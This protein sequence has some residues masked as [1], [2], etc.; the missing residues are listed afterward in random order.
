LTQTLDEKVPSPA[1]PPSASQSINKVLVATTTSLG[2]D[3]KSQ[4]VREMNMHLSWINIYGRHLAFIA[5][6]D[7]SEARIPSMTSL[8]CERIEHSDEEKNCRKSFSTS[9]RWQSVKMRN[10]SSQL[11]HVKTNYRKFSNKLMNKNSRKPSDEGLENSRNDN[12]PCGFARHK[13]PAL[14]SGWESIRGARRKGLASSKSH[15]E[16]SKFLIKNEINFS[17][18]QTF[19]RA[20]KYLLNPHPLLR[21][22][23]SSR[24]GKMLL[25]A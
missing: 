12:V 13:T 19:P 3:L 21:L 25:S 17:P 2:V 11:K 22:R 4:G 16:A 5:D 14:W 24:A 9:R 18:S 20:L 1:M 23:T 15:A 10:G 7:M 6:K 8:L